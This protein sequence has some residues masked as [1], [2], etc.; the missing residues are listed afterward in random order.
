MSM[1]APDFDAALAAPDNDDSNRTIYNLA[2]QVHKVS[3]SISGS[4]STLA[5]TAE[6]YLAAFCHDRTCS[7]TRR[8]WIGLALRNMIRTS[9]HVAHHLATRPQALSHLGDV[10]LGSSE[11]EETRIVAGIIIREAIGHGLEFH[12]FWPS[13]KV[14][15][16]APNFPPHFAPTWLYH[17]QT[18]LDTLGDLLI[19][20]THSDP[21]ILYPLSCWAS[22]N[23]TWRGSLKQNILLIQ[24]DL[25]TIIVPSASTE[26]V[27]F[28]D[29]PLQHI[30]NVRHHKASL[31]DSQAQGTTRDPWELIISFRNAPWTYRLDTS[32][33]TGHD[34]TILFEQR[35]DSEECHD[36]IK[37]FMHP[38]SSSRALNF[39]N[40]QV[41]SQALN[42]SS[43]EVISQ[44][45]SKGT[46]KSPGPS[47]VAEPLVKSQHVSTSFP[48]DFHAKVGEGEGEHANN[49]GASVTLEPSATAPSGVTV[50]N[51]IEVSSA[52]SSNDRLLLSSPDT[53]K[54]D[55]NGSLPRTNKSGHSIGAAGD[56][57][58]QKNQRDE[59][60]FPESSPRISRP[61]VRSKKGAYSHPV[62]STAH[63]FL[64][65]AT[66]AKPVGPKAK[67]KPRPQKPDTEDEDDL[68]GPRVF[69]PLA[70][71]AHPNADNHIIQ[72]TQSP[73]QP[74]N[75]GRRVEISKV[76]RVSG[77]PKISKPS[78]KQ[79]VKQSSPSQVLP[80]S[81]T[82]SIPPEDNESAQSA[83]T[84]KPRKRRA[85]V[86]KP[87][88]KPAAERN[89]K[90]TPVLDDKSNSALTPKASSNGRPRTRRRAALQVNYHESS[91]SEYSDSDIL[92]EPR[93]PRSATKAATKPK[94]VVTKKETKPTESKSK[95]E[96]SKP[97]KVKARL[98]PISPDKHRVLGNLL[99]MTQK[100]PTVQS[101]TK[102]NSAKA[103]SPKSTQKPNVEKS[104]DKERFEEGQSLSSDNAV[105]QDEDRKEG[106]F[107]SF[108]S[109]SAPA[110]VPP[111]PQVA[112]KSDQLF[113]D[114][115][116]SDK[117]P[118]V[119][120]RQS[121]AKAVPV[122]QA[123]A[124][125]ATKR[126]R[127]TEESLPATP[128]KKRSKKEHATGP[129]S[130]GQG[131]NGSAR[132]PTTIAPPR[133]LTDPSSPLGQL[134][135]SSFHPCIPNTAQYSNPSNDKRDHH[136][137]SPVV[138]PVSRRQDGYILGS[139]K[140]IERRHT[141]SH[142]SAH[143]THSGDS[144]NTEI[145][146]S[147]SKPIPASPHAESTAISGHADK[148]QVNM[149]KEMGDY[150]TARSNPFTQRAKASKLTA[151]TR[152]LTEQSADLDKSNVPMHDMASARS[153]E[154]PT[155][156]QVLESP[157]N[158]FR[159]DGR[160]HNGQSAMV[161]PPTPI[162]PRAPSLVRPEKH[163][164][165]MY[166]TPK[167][168]FQP[169][170][171]RRRS[172]EV[173]DSVVSAPPEVIG[174]TQS[175]IV[176]DDDGDVNIEGDETLVALE[177]GT[178]CSRKTS[179]LHFRSSPP[180]NCPPSSHSSTS[181]EAEHE[182]EPPIPTSEAED[183]DWEQT[184][185][186][187]LRPIHEQ[188]LRLSEHVVRH[189]ED[190]ETA[191]DGIADEYAEDGEHIINSL[192]QRHS[193]AF[194]ST[195]V[196]VEQKK[197][198]ARDEYERFA[199]RMSQECE[200]YE[201]AKH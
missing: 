103:H 27:A 100:P 18:F 76:G 58:V 7:N 1:S 151:F 113:E 169:F 46:D 158:M 183:M 149:E 134:R 174:D 177:E 11:L 192:V 168:G 131:T 4:L 20:Q 65:K 139:I 161:A 25:L 179:P 200:K 112:T 135:R 175:L 23:R 198:V 107:K 119:A 104:V 56:A 125:A 156:G 115:V 63:V 57:P 194:E 8:R 91:D 38:I 121:D 137:D 72:R 162:R 96:S 79:S 128:G 3:T 116:H 48:I 10:I 153:P 191:L 195:L 69:Q 61:S 43:P 172:A 159:V 132:R 95:P 93:K 146:S 145:L 155:E 28:V 126:K 50:Q 154:R 176:N 152:R 98:P 36:S 144:A 83:P 117:Q 42:S 16:N 184:L 2:K 60:G 142:Q 62:A 197:H 170:V 14:P 66:A 86:N 34:F 122:L 165:Q 29:I 70:P 109:P 182:P 35:A 180:G 26:D 54:R 5:A 193:G 88:G 114:F 82:F 187:H 19:M 78:V 90:A 9:E 32:E 127:T 40:P 49:E 201:S 167:Q 47:Q 123:V 141:P 39:S 17:F 80:G 160:V 196:A 67:S 120:E 166:S 75:G 55:E 77:L 21:A 105:A 89:S 84:N 41:I 157:L 186:P 24:A 163:T 133:V 45:S 13:D 73:A 147:N 148:D 189:I 178:P 22:D 51:A 68:I 106:P 85:T 33:S 164:S 124:V 108:D 52:T 74:D 185:K 71:R 129:T 31:D 6:N 143:R 150:E 30:A 99:A 64:A 101:N 87:K 15:N 110:Q 171:S 97:I 188:L 118:Q 37:Q 94:R 111:T 102:T 190:K 59:F 130:V 181:A 173:Q 138:L 44:A 199:K 136:G 12:I 81:D 53:A 140:R 92:P